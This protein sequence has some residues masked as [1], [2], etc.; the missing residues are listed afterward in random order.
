MSNVNTNNKLEWFASGNAPLLYPTELVTGF[1]IFEDLSML[2]IPP[3][4]PFATTWGKPV[5]VRL[6]YEKTHPIPEGIAMTWFSIVENKFYA[7]MDELP[8]EQIATLLSE[9]DENT[10]KP[11]YNTLIAGMA[12]GGK[13]AVWVSGNDITTEVA[14]LQGHEIEMDIDM[15]DPNTKLTQEE[16]AK[17]ALANCEEALQNFNQNGLPAPELFD[18]YMQK[19]NYRITPIFE[20]EVGE[21]KIYIHYYNGE[22]NK[23]NP[24]EPTEN[25][26]RAKP[27]KI[28]LTWQTK[29]AKYNGYFW[30]DEQKIIETFQNAFDDDIENKEDNI[31]KEGNLIIKIDSSFKNFTFILQTMA[32]EIEIPAEEMQYLIFKN[33]FEYCRS[34]NYNKPKG[35]WRD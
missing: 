21:I 6:S 11:K 3:S 5:S 16:Y 22:L 9:K 15:L 8:K 10:K 27:Y 24:Q 28:T 29:K 23:I 19:F 4:V 31:E 18:Q 1:F 7:V 14:W 2:E 34:N 26:L 12:P 32:H 30:T 33:K 20:S 13:V 17:K 25:A 35:S